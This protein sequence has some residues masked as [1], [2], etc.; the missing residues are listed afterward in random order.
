[1]GSNDKIRDHRLLVWLSR[2]LACLAL[3]AGFNYWLYNHPPEALAN[4]ANRYAIVQET[5]NSDYVGFQAY[6]L[7]GNPS[8]VPAG[9]FS[10][11]TLWAINTNY[12]GGLSWVETGW[13]KPGTAALKYK[14]IYKVPQYGCVYTENSPA[15]SPS[16]DSWHIYRMECP[17]CANQVWALYID[18]VYKKQLATG[19]TNG[20]VNRLDAGGEVGGHA[21]PI[22]MDGP[23]VNIIRY[24]RGSTWYYATQWENEFCTT[25]YWLQYTTADHNNIADGGY[26]PGGTC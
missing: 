12:C 22:G 20:W 24:K 21:A 4:H 5:T 17:S 1:M 18:D 15:G 23:G 8:P 14:W 9:T 13:Y 11:Q 6:I 16:V 3:I 25:G 2:L 19:W 7:T 10:N 26:S